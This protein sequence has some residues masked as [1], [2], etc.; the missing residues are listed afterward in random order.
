MPTNPLTEEEKTEAVYYLDS[1]LRGPFE[2]NRKQLGLALGYASGS[3][4]NMVLSGQR[5]PSQHLYSAAK[6]L[7]QQGQTKLQNLTAA[8]QPQPAATGRGTLAELDDIYTNLGRIVDRLHQLS[9]SCVPL[10]RPGLLQYAE[11]LDRG[12]KVLEIA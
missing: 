6:L 12:R 11:Q 5:E 2:G 7:W 3:L 10:L 1:M 4:I 9:E 8:P